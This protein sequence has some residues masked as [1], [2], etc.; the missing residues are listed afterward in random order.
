[1]FEHVCEFADFGVQLLIRV[2]ARVAGFAF[3]D[4]RG[5]VA[6]PG[7]EVTIETV[8]GNVYLAAAEP[9]RVWRVPLQDRVPLFEPVKLFGHAC[10]K[11][12]R[13]GVR[14]SA[15]ALDF[16]FGFNVRFGGKLRWGREEPIFLKHGFDVRGDSRHGTSLQV[17]DFGF[18]SCFACLCI[19]ELLDATNE[20]LRWYQR[21][22]L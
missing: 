3:P 22:Q 10:P 16:G 2:R 18:S 15:Q 14:F 11:S 21:V 6:A 7:G 1:M 4:E 17:L 20:T 5:F 8:V 13:I 19:T 12:F 9:F